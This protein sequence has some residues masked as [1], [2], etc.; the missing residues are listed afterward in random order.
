MRRLAHGASVR[1]VL[2]RTELCVSFVI[3][4]I[5]KPHRSSSQRADSTGASWRGAQVS[6]SIR[7]ERNEA[8]AYLRA[9]GAHERRRG[10]WPSKDILQPRKRNMNQVRFDCRNESILG[11]RVVEVGDKLAFGWPP[12]GPNRSSG[13]TLYRSEGSLYD[14]RAHTAVNGGLCGVGLSHRLRPKSAQPKLLRLAGR[15][16]LVYQHV[17]MASSS[18]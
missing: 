3:K 2:T 16:G 4:N 8:T 12:S 5:K 17:G 1:F 9:L 7:S 18:S 6:A 13:P 11:R 15:L 10:H 14:F